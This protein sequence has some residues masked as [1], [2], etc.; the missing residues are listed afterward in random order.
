MIFTIKKLSFLRKKKAENSEKRGQLPLP[1][2]RRPSAS[3]LAASPASQ[4]QD[5][6]GPLAFDVASTVEFL[7]CLAVLGFDAES[8][9][10]LR[11]DICGPRK[12]FS[13]THLVSKINNDWFVQIADLAVR[14]GFPVVTPE[15]RT[16]FQ[17]VTKVLL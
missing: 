14:G 8:V 17:Q 3:V 10:Q 15:A 2:H 13:L 16:K 11:K 7:G 12:R 4:L 6:D 5:N 1:A 9:E